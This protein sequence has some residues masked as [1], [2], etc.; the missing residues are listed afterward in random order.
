MIGIDSMARRRPATVTGAPI[1]PADPAGR[2]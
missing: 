2:I 1:Q